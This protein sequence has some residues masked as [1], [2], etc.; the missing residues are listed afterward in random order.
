MVP[1]GHRLNAF[2]RNERM[3]SPKMT[4]HRDRPPESTPMFARIRR[5][6]KF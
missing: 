1:G 6:Y 4:A 3:A 5:N 2:T